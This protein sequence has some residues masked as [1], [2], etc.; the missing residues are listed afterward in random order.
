MILRN[1][2][3]T[4]LIILYFA[5]YYILKAVFPEIDND[6]DVFLNFYKARNTLYEGMFFLSFAINFLNTKGLSKS[7]S[8]FGMCVT[9][10][11]LID[12]GFYN[13]TGYLWSDILTVAVAGGVSIYIYIKWKKGEAT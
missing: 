2:I 12:K 11:S 9:F 3:L 8:C 10:A 7:L 5:N 6:Y 1:T 13:I 4:V